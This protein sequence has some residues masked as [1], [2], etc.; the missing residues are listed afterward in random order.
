MNNKMMAIDEMMMVNN[1]MKLEDYLVDLWTEL[2]FF[3]RFDDY[4]NFRL[5]KIKNPNYSYKDVPV[6][7]E[8]ADGL[9]N[10]ISHTTLMFEPT[11]N[12]IDYV[13]DKSLDRFIDI[14]LKE[15]VDTMKLKLDFNF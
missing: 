1:I 15:Y 5:E 3:A 2:I 13:L 8:Y 7:N 14:Q 6:F 11:S 12:V 4:L 10:K 9:K